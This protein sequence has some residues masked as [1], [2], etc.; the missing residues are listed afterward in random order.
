MIKGQFQIKYKNLWDRI[1]NKPETGTVI[2]DIGLL[3]S[4]K[5][6]RGKKK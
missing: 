5:K 6:P 3:L 2:V 1:R 4:K